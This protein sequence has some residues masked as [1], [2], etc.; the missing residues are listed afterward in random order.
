MGNPLRERR[1]AADLAAGAQ[2]IEFAK[3]VSDFER[4]SVI[5]EADLAALDAD[6]MPA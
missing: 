6:R 1:S 3:K 5:I 2:V 4:L